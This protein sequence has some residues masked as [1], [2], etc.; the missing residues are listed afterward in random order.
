VQDYLPVNGHQPAIADPLGE[1][2][3]LMTSDDMAGSLSMTS[4][5]QTD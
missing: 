5:A 4:V 1:L 3:H 2:S